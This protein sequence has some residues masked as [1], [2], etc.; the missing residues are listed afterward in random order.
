MQL[1]HHRRA[2]IAVGVLVNALLA[3]SVHAQSGQVY[4]NG[5][6]FDG[7]GFR[8]GERY[9]VSGQF[10][11]QRPSQVDRVVDL[12]NAFVVP[13]FAEA[14]SHNVESSRYDAVSRMHLERG[15]FY[16]R[17]PNSLPRFTE[18]LRG[19]LN[20]PGLLDATFA[21]GGLTSTGGHP[22]AI[23]ARQISRGTWL[24]AEGDGGF[25][26]NIDSVA[27]LN[28]KWPRI[29]AA[30]PDFIKT[31]LLHSEQY[32]RR[33]VDTAFL[34]WRGLNPAILPEIV[35][36][37]HQANLRVSTHVETAF[38]FRQAV[39]AGVDEI[40]HLPGFRPDRNR[41]RDY[42][43]LEQ[44]Q[45]TDDDAQ[46]AARAGVSV[47]T[48]VGGIVEILRAVPPSDSS[49]ALAARTLTMLRDNIRRLHRAGVRIAIGSDEYE[50]SADFEIAQLSVLG[51][52]DALTLFTWWV[53]VTP[54]TI[55]PTRKL[56]RLQPDY[57]ASFLV[58]SSNPILQLGDR[59][60]MVMR[61]K[62]GIDLDRPRN[63]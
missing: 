60:T 7:T 43:N 56:G 39:A 36:R 19:R 26:W 22:T 49:A 48:T 59:S 33:A 9:V 47:V 23:A 55:F 5:Q 4:T 25:Y 53:E 37:A 46:R 12:R 11:T 61:V 38:D 52:V 1:G 29:L 41:L 20:G 40:N 16:V 62:Q 42:E 14:H 21:N 18:P 32:A 54:A 30:R 35:R 6:W 57:E 63:P 58:F 28:A 44:Y 3:T 31:Y 50:R 51:A 10:V 27:D 34:D 17:N 24:A 15:V 45:L 13:P 2:R 8:A